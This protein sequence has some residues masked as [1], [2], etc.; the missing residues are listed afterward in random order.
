MN[1]LSL[2]LLSVLQLSSSL[3]NWPCTCRKLVLAHVNTMGR[4]EN[5]HERKP[6]WALMH[7][8]SHSTLLLGNCLQAL[9]RE[10]DDK[11]MLT[12]GSDGSTGCLGAGLLSAR[13][14]DGHIPSFGN[15][16]ECAKSMG[17][18]RGQKK[19]KSC[20]VG[21]VAAALVAS[22]GAKCLLRAAVKRMQ[23]CRAPVSVKALTQD[24]ASKK[25]AF[26][27]CSTCNQSNG[28]TKPFGD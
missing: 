27:D 22:A 17:R 2:V 24:R 26:A 16:L 15:K 13:G 5:K 28:S 21:I 9:T 12:A 20:I 10:L 18:P 23:G 4:M 1:S 11:A 6:L 19:A 25:L 7:L 8:I 3:Y 14:S